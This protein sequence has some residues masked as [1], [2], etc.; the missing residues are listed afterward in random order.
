MINFER[1]V[2]KRL[3]GD[4]RGAI[5]PPHSQFVYIDTFRQSPPA[6]S[7]SKSLASIPQT[8]SGSLPT[9][10]EFEAELGRG[11]PEEQQGDAV[12]ADMVDEAHEAED[13]ED[14]G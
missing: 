5:S 3:P 9:V 14:V 8:L 6:V 12:E 11:R 1:S 2:Q 10:E 7:E 4:I 13:T